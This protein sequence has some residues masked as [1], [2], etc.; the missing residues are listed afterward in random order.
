MAE[1]GLISEIVEQECILDESSRY[2]SNKDIKQTGATPILGFV[3]P[4]NSRLNWV[5]MITAK[6]GM[7]LQSCSKQNSHTLVLVG[8]R[9]DGLQSHNVCHLEIRRSICLSTVCTMLIRTG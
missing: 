2:S 6:M 1:R 3:T 8:C 9:S 5:F 4:W 7:T